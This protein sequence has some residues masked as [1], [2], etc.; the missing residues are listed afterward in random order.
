MPDHFFDEL[1]R[2]E[3]DLLTDDAP[4]AVREHL[5]NWLG[6]AATPLQLAVAE[7]KARSMQELAEIAGLRIDRTR[8]LE[9]RTLVERA[10][11]RDARGRFVARG[12]KRIRQFLEEET[13]F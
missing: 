10:V 11:L 7:Q 5:R 2:D 9:G 4:E 6:F 13:A 8:L 12:A 1:D 3:I